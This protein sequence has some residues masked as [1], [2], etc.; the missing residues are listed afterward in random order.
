MEAFDL[1]QMRGG[2]ELFL[3]SAANYMHVTYG[4]S[5]SLSGIG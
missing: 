2:R 4:K 1:A 5:L 3:S